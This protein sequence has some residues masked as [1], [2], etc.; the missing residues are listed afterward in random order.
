MAK[1]PNPSPPSGGA[2]A[3]TLS[4]GF[5]DLAN[6]L[7]PFAGALNQARQALLN[8][9]GTVTQFVDAI[10]PSVVFELNQAFRDLSATIGSAFISVVQ[11]AASVV[12]E[13]GGVLLPVLQ[14]FTPI[15]ATAA[16]AVGNLFI[17]VVRLLVAPLQL[18]VPLLDIFVAATAEVDKVLTDLVTIATAVVRM[19]VEMTQLLFGALFGND[20]VGSLKEVFRQLADIV[21]QVIK[22]LLTFAATLATSL[23][24][25]GY[26]ERFAAALDKE[27]KER[28]ARA[29]GLKAAA[30][31]PQIQDIASIARQAQLAAFTAAGG[32]PGREKSDTQWLQELSKDL[33]TI[34]TDNRS[35]ED[36]LKDWWENQVV[37]STGVFGRVL[38]GVEGMLN[39]MMAAFDRL[40]RL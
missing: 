38:R 24:G 16:N 37:G 2:S 8:V 26:V 21:R 19:F 27:A 23:G 17:S 31:S 29:G 25:A 11:V 22:A 28:D 4:A 40:S 30:N 7:V 34:A 14:Q 3:A 20:A 1:S 10:A 18:L 32:G 13:L 39:T 33:K 5:A 35:I 15:I 12:R 6:T 9:V 36:K